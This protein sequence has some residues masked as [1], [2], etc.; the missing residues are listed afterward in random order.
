MVTDTIGDFLSRIRNAQVRKKTHVEVPSSNMLK[1]I[2]HILK[3]EGFIKDAVDET[4]AE[5]NHDIL[6]I[7][8]RYENDKPAIKGIKRES[9]PG[10][11]TYIGYR[12]IKKVMQ[13]LGISILT[14]PKGIM[15]GEKARKEKTGG[16]LLCTI[17]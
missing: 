8:L 6:R 9:K 15:T 4:D 5:K 16:E 10:V 1:G 12:D 3:E 7:E 13:G 17:W 11:R 2:A 14:T